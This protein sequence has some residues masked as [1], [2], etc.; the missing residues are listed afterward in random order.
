M[1]T[2]VAEL[3]IRADLDNMPDDGRRYE[4]ID[5]S[6]LVTPSPGFCHQDVTY[7]LA[8]VLDQA[9]LGTG[10]HMTIGPFDVVL[11]ANTVL[12]PDIIVAPRGS[13]TERTVQVHPSLIV[14]VRSPSTARFDA[15]LKRDLYADAGVP[16]YWLVDPV[17]P[18]II[19]LELV[20]GRYVER[21]HAVG[22]EPL[23]VDRPF[24]VVV[25]PADLLT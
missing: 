9:A 20:D 2:M 5:G 12:I 24:P 19:V 11:S 8:T 23:E 18:S 15:T 10:W 3:L 6:L 1:A 14:E 21:A 13:F 22:S 17:G 16:Y 7:R 25:T 4:L